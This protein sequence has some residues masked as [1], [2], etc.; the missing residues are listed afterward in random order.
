MCITRYTTLDRPQIINSIARN[1]IV[2]LAVNGK[3]VSI[4]E[5][6]NLLDLLSQQGLDAAVV[7]IEVNRCIIRKESFGGHVLHAGDRVEI[8]RFVGGG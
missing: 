7:V 2:E 6:S 1:Y 4:R 8:L 3:P 5:G